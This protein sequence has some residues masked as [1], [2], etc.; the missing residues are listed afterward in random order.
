MR[1]GLFAFLVYLGFA[2]SVQAA[3]LK[4]DLAGYPDKDLWR[5]VEEAR[6]RCL[7]A[8]NGEE[9]KKFEDEYNSKWSPKI[10]G[11]RKNAE[12]L[13][14]LCM[15]IATKNHIESKVTIAT[16]KGSDKTP[17]AKIKY[18]MIGEDKVITANNPSQCEEN[19]TIGLYHIWSERKVEG[20]EQP[21]SKESDVHP[22]V[23][24]A[25]TVTLM[26]TR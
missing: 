23:S 5:F 20:K 24:P 4:R 7:A 19:L 14:A 11:P 16:Q 3:D 22:I 6:P 9:R 26:E 2:V 15:R 21:T 25:F 10:L 13:A 12:E 1:Q 18:R 17:G 8:L